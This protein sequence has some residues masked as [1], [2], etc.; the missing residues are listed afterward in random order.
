MDRPTPAM[1]S[2]QI[3]QLE[4]LD[5]LRAHPPF[6]ALP[7][8][9][10]QTPLMLLKPAIA[11]PTA[12]IFGS[13]ALKRDTKPAILSGFAA[14]AQQN[15]DQIWDFGANDLQAVAQAVCPD[16]SDCIAWLSAKGLKPRM[17]GSGSAVFAPWV[18]GTDLSDAPPGWQIKIC[19][20]WAEH[21]LRAWCEG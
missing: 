4:I 21:P 2:M 5:F 6:D 11:V 17:T 18:E 9:V 10:L 20:N 12:A 8:E 7:D 3:E 14:D 16:I 19:S 1:A 15:P 13:D